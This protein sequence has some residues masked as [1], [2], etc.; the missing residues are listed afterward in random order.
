MT[1]L[2]LLFAATLLATISLAQDPALPE[3]LKKM[4]MFAGV[5]TGKLESDKGPAEVKMT[6]KW[7]EDGK[8]FESRVTIQ[9]AG[10][11]PVTKTYLFG[12][13]GGAG[14]IRARMLSPRSDT[15]RVSHGK[16]DKEKN[17]VLFKKDPWRNDVNRS[18]THISFE[19]KA[20]DKLALILFFD[21][22]D[23]LFGKFSGT[24]QLS[25][26]DLGSGR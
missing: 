25:G 22:A 2:L 8:F 17:K 10:M 3:S 26:T 9:V 12:G 13:D 1:K 15:P 23:S 4:N 5:W 14:E 24:L 16:W 11:S 18:E 6:N 19:Q 21:E 20:K 7:I